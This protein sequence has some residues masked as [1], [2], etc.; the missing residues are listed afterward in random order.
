MPANG[1]QRPA[2]DQIEALFGSFSLGTG[3]YVGIAVLVAL[4]T[5]VAALTSRWTVMRTLSAID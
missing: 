5:G 4:V 2:G 1:A 3:G